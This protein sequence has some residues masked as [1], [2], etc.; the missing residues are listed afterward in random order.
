MGADSKPLNAT[1]RIL[2][3]VLA[4]PMRSAREIAA[5]LD[6]AQTFVAEAL[7]RMARQKKVV[8]EQSGEGAVNYWRGITDD[9]GDA[10]PVTRR[11]VSTWK[12]HHFRDPLVAA[13]HGPAGI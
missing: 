13:I 2:A 12:P 3:H 10:I 7:H 6:L 8:R 1:Q 5:E 4:N 9:D 11:A